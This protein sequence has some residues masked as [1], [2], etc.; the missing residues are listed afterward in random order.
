MSQIRHN[1]A[2]G[3]WVIIAPERAGRPADFAAG[4]R[5]SKESRPEHVPTCPFCPGNEDHTPP[6][7]LRL[8]QDGPWQVRVVPNKFA[9][10]QRE[11]SRKP[12]SDGLFHAL[13]GTGWHEVAVESRRH[14]APTALQTAEEIVR[15]LTALQLRGIKMAR[16]PRIEQIVY[17]K[18]HGPSAGTSREHPH[19]QIMALPLVPS[20]LLA[21]A[22]VARRYFEEGGDCAFCQTWQTEAASGERVVAEGE[23]FLAFVPYAAFAPY[24]TWIVPKRHRASFCRASADELA[25]LGALLRFVLQKIR[26]GLGDPDYNCVIQ[27]APVS[28]SE[29]DHLHWYATVTPRLIPWG[30]LEL[31]TGMFVNPASPEENA[32]F[33]RDVAAQS[34][35]PKPR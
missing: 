28:L 5:A 33:L 4:E 15:T 31:G 7:V 18:N 1:L 35:T 26:L 32:R 8:P 22:E 34:P 11:G 17:L 21:Q 16:D 6:E 25:D 2:T 29:S 23:C 19:S 20:R 10:L 13:S 30:S 3:E 14:N 9:A 12:H 27:S 24:H